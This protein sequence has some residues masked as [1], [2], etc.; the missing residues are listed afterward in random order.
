ML[1]ILNKAWA[2]ILIRQVIADPDKKFLF[3]IS[4]E[5]EDRSIVDQS[6]E[7]V[8]K[9][10]DSSEQLN[11]VNAYLID[12]VVIEDLELFKSDEES[13]RAEFPMYDDILITSKLH[14]MMLKSWLGQHCKRK[15]C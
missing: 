10:A 2:K 3:V 12:Y 4:N 13:G 8:F 6:V 14:D 5:D 11:I 15:C 9:D 1:H 7:E